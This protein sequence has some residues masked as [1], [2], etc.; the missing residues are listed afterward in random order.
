MTQSP[1]SGARPP[2]GYAAPS[3][4][5]RTEIELIWIEQRLEHWIRFGRIAGERILS[6]KTRVVIFRP[7]AIIAFVRWSANDYGTIHSRIDILRAVRSG[8][9]YTTAPFVR[10][11][12]ELLLSIQGW[13]K[14]RSVIEAI[15]QV[16]AVGLDPCD[17]ASDH[18]RHVHNRLSAG[19]Q[20]RDYTAERHQAWLGRKAL[21]R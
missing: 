8:E 3:R 19:E 6:R 5:G 17:I 11:G 9:P 2:S 15:D 16:E 18:W 7:D 21:G 13:Q 1:P 20:P 10:P 4:N 14:V 12:G